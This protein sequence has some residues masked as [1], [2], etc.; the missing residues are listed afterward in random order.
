MSDDLENGQMPWLTLRLDPEALAAAAGA[1]LIGILLGLLWSPLFWVGFIG[2]VVCLMAGR[3]SSR[4]APDMPTAIVAPCDGRVV[5]VMRADPPS[6]LR[7][8][9]EA[10]MRVRIASAPTST[11]KLYAPI[12]SSVESIILEAGEQTAFFASRPHQEGLSQAFVTF[13]SQGQEVGVHLSQGGFGPRLDLDVEDGDVLRL[14]RR[15]GTRRLG[16][17]CDLYVPRRAGMLVWPGQTL[18]GGETVVARLK[19]E[20]DTVLFDDEA[21][22]PEVPEDAFIEDTDYVPEPKTQKADVQEMDDDASEDPSDVFAKLREAVRKEA[23][24][25]EG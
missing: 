23:G 13:D 12:S 2:M 18:I 16:G 6:E 25:E 19:A 11:N 14:G 10:M 4:K 7:I 15:F 17:W 3:W 1:L 21:E 24:E 9:A 20:D 22:T 8:E 5:S